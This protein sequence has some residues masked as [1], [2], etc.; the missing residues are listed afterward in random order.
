MSTP[1]VT[2]DCRQRLAERLASAPAEFEANCARH[3]DVPATLLCTECQRWFCADCATIDATDLALVCAACA[4]R[5]RRRSVTARLLALLREPFVYVGLAAGLALV[6]WAFGVGNPDTR[7]ARPIDARHPWYT[8]RNGVLW[9]RQAGRAKK[10]AAALAERQRHKEMAA[11]ATLAEQAFHRAAQEWRQTDAY[12]DLCVG[13][14]LMQARRGD[15]AGACERLGEVETDMKPGHPSRAA[16]LYHRAAIALQAGRRDA[17]SADLRE[18]AALLPA[19]RADAPLASINDLIDQLTD[20]Y[21]KDR[22]GA[23]QHNRVRTVCETAMSAQELRGGLEDLNRDHGLNLAEAAR[24]ADPE[25]AAT[26]R[27]EPTAAPTTPPSRL[28]IR[29]IEEP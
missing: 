8:Q 19:P 4:E 5:R 27:P 6:L 22:A 16:L 10:R 1:D 14:A 15:P 29:R 26:A 18:L 7:Q 3:E 13:E 20:F 17:A 21:G 11:W 9:L 24:P 25:R 28:Q 12:P 23:V 2:S